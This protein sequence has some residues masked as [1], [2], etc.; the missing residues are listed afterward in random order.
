MSAAETSVEEVR[1]SDQEPITEAPFDGMAELSVPAPTPAEST[2]DEEVKHW[3]EPDI[4]VLDQ[5]LEGIPQDWPAKVENERPDT[6]REQPLEQKEPAVGTGE[7]VPAPPLEEKKS[8]HEP[9]QEGLI[10]IEPLY[11]I[12]YFASQG[13]QLTDE[14]KLDPLGRKLKSF[15]E[16]LKTMKKV[17]PEKT[18]MSMDDKTEGSIKEGAEHSNDRAEVVTEAMAEVYLKQG[19]KHKAL[20]VYQKLSLLNPSHSASFAAKIAELKATEL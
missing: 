2:V 20:E 8:V 6:Y 3:S 9:A 13:I 12:D 10:P 18:K 19:L 5:P 15:T 1:V 16:W 17:H 14:E 11:T 4:R 7:T